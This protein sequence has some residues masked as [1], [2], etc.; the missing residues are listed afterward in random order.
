MSGRTLL[1]SRHPGAQQWLEAEAAARSWKD[2]AILPHLELE[3]L[4]A[5]TPA[6]VAGVLPLA[7]AA[8]LTRLG[9]EVWHLDLVP[10][11][12]DRGQELSCAQMKRLG[13][14]LCRYEVHQLC[15]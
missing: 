7:I 12:G 9:V 11:P 14:R 1:V 10:G 4:S 13:A 3:A 6:R 2:I 5:R 8:R 15:R